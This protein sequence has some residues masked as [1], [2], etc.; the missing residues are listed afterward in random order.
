MVNLTGSHGCLFKRKPHYSTIRVDEK[1]YKPLNTKT[2][3]GLHTARKDSIY[4]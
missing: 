3:T 4:L 2:G 1:L